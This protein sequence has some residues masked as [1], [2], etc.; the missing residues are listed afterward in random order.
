[1]SDLIILFLVNAIGWKVIKSSYFSAYP[2]PE[3]VWARWEVPPGCHGSIPAVSQS[4]GPWALQALQFCSS[5]P[6][7]LDTIFTW[8]R[9][10]WWSQ[11]RMWLISFGFLLPMVVGSHPLRSLQPSH[12]FPPH[13]MEDTPGRVI[14]EGCSRPC[15]PQEK[16]PWVLG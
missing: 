10:E 9:E 5:L 3:L 7:P 8:K 6:K 1:M 11:N 15:L 4:V 13:G 14:K 12:C 2:C 16:S